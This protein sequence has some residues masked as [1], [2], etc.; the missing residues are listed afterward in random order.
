[1]SLVI[2]VSKT[3]EV[4]ELQGRSPR[5]KPLSL[6]LQYLEGKIESKWVYYTMCASGREIQTREDWKC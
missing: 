1:M 6:L 2:G 5:F 3:S 4:L